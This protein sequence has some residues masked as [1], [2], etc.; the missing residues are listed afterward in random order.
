MWGPCSLKPA[1]QGSSV[2]FDI[3][4][5]NQAWGQDISLQRQLQT[6]AQASKGMK[7]ADEMT[8]LAADMLCIS[9]SRVYVDPLV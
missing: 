9:K 4:A 5:S 1:G 2:S 6:H 7:D 8:G 3:S